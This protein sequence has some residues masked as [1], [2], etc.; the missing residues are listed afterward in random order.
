[1]NLQFAEGGSAYHVDISGGTNLAMQQAW[2]VLP[3]LRPHFLLIALLGG[4]LASPTTH[5]MTLSPD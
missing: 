1:M 5:S 4:K 3:L 2:Y